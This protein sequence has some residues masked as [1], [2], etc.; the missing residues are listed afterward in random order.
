MAHELQGSSAEGSERIPSKVSPLL[1]RISARD[2]KLRGENTGSGLSTG[3]GILGG[4][5]KG[6]MNDRR[7]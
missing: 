1:N 6:D 7:A 4:K 5:K 2:S 3:V